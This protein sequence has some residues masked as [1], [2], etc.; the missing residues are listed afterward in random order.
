MSVD[1]IVRCNVRSN[2][3]AQKKQRRRRGKKRKRKRRS[4]NI[5]SCR[6]NGKRGMLVGNLS[7]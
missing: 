7:I 5:R 2:Y 4:R 1:D 3:T 6:E